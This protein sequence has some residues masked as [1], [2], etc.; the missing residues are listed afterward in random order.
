MSEQTAAV[1]NGWMNRALNTIEVIGNKLPD[2]AVLFALLMV[3][4]WGLSWLFS[5]MTF[6]EID[7]R[8]GQQ[9]QI[10]NGSWSEGAP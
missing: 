8:S 4:V 7:P 10:V 3:I 6:T 9:V 5:G 1:K 2:P